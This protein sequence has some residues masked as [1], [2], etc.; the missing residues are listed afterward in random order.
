[1]P[2][3]LCEWYQ[4][5]VIGGAEGKGHWTCK[6]DLYDWW[7]RMIKAGA[8]YHHRYFVTMC[9]A[10][11][12]VKSGIS[13]EELRSDVEKLIPVLSAIYPPEPF[14]RADADSALECYDER[15]VT[16]PIEDISRLSA[17]P[18]QKN[19][20]NG[21]PQKVHLMMTRSIQQIGDQVNETNWRDGNGRKS[22]R[23]EVRK[24]RQSHPDGRKVD[25]IRE[26][27]LGKTTV[28]KYWEG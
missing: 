26:T 6:R 2:L 20:R 27:G 5:R 24:W 7:K 11:Y 17:I 1:M 16:F 14:T 9:L 4:R 18:I 22:K 19:K 10:I 21:R 13:W 25:C 3:P 15:Y 23:D 12:A 28:Y 8:T